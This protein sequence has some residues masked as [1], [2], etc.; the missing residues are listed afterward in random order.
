MPDDNPTQPEGARMLSRG[1]AG[2]VL[3]RRGNTEPKYRGRGGGT[4][5]AAVPSK[6]RKSSMAPRPVAERPECEPEASEFRPHPNAP[7]TRP[8]Y[9]YGEDYESSPAYHGAAAPEPAPAGP[10]GSHNQPPAPAG[11]ES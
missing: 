6:V 10:E 8:Q 5:R 7:G 3:P 11:S 1:R 9:T 4:M 2:P